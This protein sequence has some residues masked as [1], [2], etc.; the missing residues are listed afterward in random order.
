LPGLATRKLNGIDQCAWLR[1]A[2]IR[3]A[4]HPINRVDELL[5]WNWAARIGQ[6]Q[7]A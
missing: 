5:P 4:A 2:L 1:D 3:G 6:L 7:A